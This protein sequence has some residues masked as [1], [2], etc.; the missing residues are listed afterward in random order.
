MR[1]GVVLVSLPLIAFASFFLPLS[2]FAEP[3]PQGTI[4]ISVGDN[5]FC[6]PSFRYAVCPTTV[7]AGET[8]LWNY[9]AGVTQHTVTECD[10]QFIFCPNQGGFNSG[11]FAVGNSFRHTFNEPGTFYYR[12]NVHPSDMRGSVLVQPQ[13][14]P[15]PSLSPSPQPSPSPSAIVPTPSAT[16]SQGDTMTATS[17]PAAVPAGGGQPPREGNAAAATWYAVAAGLLFVAA[18]AIALRFRQH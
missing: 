16:L 6:A 10:A 1:L 14:T 5:W 3:A 18:A 9:A 2:S 17:S 8:I 4:N 11:Y 13:P 12:C 15:T 7:T